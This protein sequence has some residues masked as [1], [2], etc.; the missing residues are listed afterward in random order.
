[1]ARRSANGRH[2]ER[3]GGRV[4]EARRRGRSRARPRRRFRPAR[5]GR[6][7]GS[8]RSPRRRARRRAPPPPSPAS[9][10]ASPGSWPCVSSSSMNSARSRR[11]V[12]GVRR[13]WAIAASIAVRSRMKRSSR[14]RMRLKATFACRVSSGPVS[15]SG[16]KLSPRPSR[17]AALASCRSGALA[18]RMPSAPTIADGD[19]GDQERGEEG[20]AERRHRRPVGEGVQPAAVGRAGSRRCTQR[21]RRRWPGGLVVVVF[22]GVRGPR[23]AACRTTT[24][25]S[26]S[27]LLQR[28]GEARRDSA[29]RRRR[30]VGTT[31]GCGSSEMR[32]SGELV[33][34][35]QRARAAPAAPPREARR[36][37]RGGRRGP[38]D[39]RC[40]SAATRSPAKSA[41]VTTCASDQRQDQKRRKPAREAS[42]AR[43]S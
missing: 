19:G 34:A 42:S 35:T 32:K 11:L 24:R 31:S 15:G 30:R 7:G 39:R 13:S 2:L 23:Q 36:A 5:S 26:S 43:A 12:I 40:G 9:R 14:S 22:V 8:P 4:H 3:D 18:Q 38:R 37:R 41:K 33:A 29:A 21:G 10:R 27:G 28:S 16:S 25:T 6:S 1:M 20:A 17:S